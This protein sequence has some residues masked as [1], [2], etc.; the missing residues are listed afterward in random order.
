MPLTCG[1]ASVLSI[2]GSTD[3]AAGGAFREVRRLVGCTLFI[4]GLLLNLIEGPDNTSKFGGVD[5]A[6]R[7]DNLAGGDCLESAQE[8]RAHNLAVG[9][10]LRDRF[11]DPYLFRVGAKVPPIAGAT[12]SAVV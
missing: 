5:N 7:N 10:S 9:W 1:A 6:N 8:S 3:G 12:G 4:I 11:H 2:C